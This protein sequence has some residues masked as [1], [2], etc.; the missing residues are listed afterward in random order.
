MALTITHT[1]INAITDW[2][3]AQLDA[4]I[5]LGNFPPGTLLAD[6]TLPSDWNANHTLSGSIAWGEVTGTLSNQTDLQNALNAKVTGPASSTDN[7]VVRYDGTTGK[8]AQNSGITIDDNNAF[9]NVDAITFNTSPTTAAGTGILR[10]NSTEGVLEFGTAFT[11]NVIQIGMESIIRARNNTGSTITNGT[12]VY[13]SG[14]TG[15]RPTIAMADASVASTSETILGLVTAD[16]ANNAD[17]PVTTFGIVRDLNTSGY[18]EGVI[19]WLSETTGQ[20]TSVK[21]ALPAIAIRVGVVTKSHITQGEILVNPDIVTLDPADIISGMNATKI[22]D[23]TVSNAEFQYLNGVTS[24]IQTQIDGKISDPS[25]SNGSIL[26]NI[27]GSAV[28]VDES[29]IHDMCLS[30]T[31]VNGLT[32]QQTSGA[33]A[34]ATTKASDEADHVGIVQLETG[35]TTTGYGRHLNSDGVF[36]IVGATGKT[37]R[38][39]AMVKIPTLA[40]G[41]EDFDAFIGFGDLSGASRVSARNAVGILH[42]SSYANF[43]LIKVDGA[44]GTPVYV[45]T[46]IPVTANTWYDLEVEVDMHATDT[47]VA[48]RAYIDG[49][50]VGSGTDVNSGNHA[51]VFCYIVK[52]AGTTERTML[53]DRIEWDTRTT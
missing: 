43:Q 18:S 10:W 17:G 9:A 31:T 28:W 11:S 37:A 36:T 14:A 53:V 46:G 22:A 51:I 27:R 24:A 45:D 7:A 2:T 12:P 40:T 23:G 49:V 13:V 38:V 4:Q 32:L 3:Q 6:I 19:L 15:N 29:F 25:P 20:L 42:N 30:R 44:G 8:L 39:R 1:K 5:A 16:I 50:Q 26:K 47:S 48:Y 21:P 52:F 33:G 35:T 34:S 41:A